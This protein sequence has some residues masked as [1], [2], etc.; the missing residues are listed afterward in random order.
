MRDCM[1]ENQERDFIPMNRILIAFV[2]CIC[3]F[4]GCSKS[5]NGID[6]TTDFFPALNVDFYINLSLP[7]ASP[8][9]FPQGWIYQ[10]GGYRGIIVYRNFDEYLAFDRTCPY[11]TDS[12]CSYVSVDSSNTFM[13]CGQYVKNFSKCCDSRF[14]L[15]NGTVQQGPAIRPLKQYYVR[16]EGNSLHVTSSPF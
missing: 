14:Y 7:S 11:K 2:S 8:L 6:P 3:L 16:Q 15:L 13:R 12:S 4:S 9:L 1:V 5:S 10:Q